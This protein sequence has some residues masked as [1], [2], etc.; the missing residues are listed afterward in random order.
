M[1]TENKKP[2]MT[3]KMKSYEIEPQA[4]LAGSGVEDIDNGIGFGGID[5]YG[6]RDVD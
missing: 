4:L 5:N 1:K 3:P 6:D 2:Y